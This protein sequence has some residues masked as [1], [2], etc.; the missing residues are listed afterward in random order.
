MHQDKTP[1]PPQIKALHVSP[2]CAPLSKKGG[3]GDVAG[4]LPKALRG[5][6]VDAR[7]LTP[8][9]PGVLDKARELGALPQRPVGAVSVAINWRA[10]TAKV[11]R[12]NISGL[13]VY[14]LENDELFSNGDIYPDTLNAETAEPMIFLSYAA[15]ELEH[16]AKWKPYIIH[17]HDWPT[18]A[19]PAALRWHRHYA[20]R[21]AD[22]DTV[23]TIHNIAH[24]GLFS[25]DCL[26]GWGFRPDSYWGTFE[27]YGQ[28]N[29]MKGAINNAEAV[30]AVS[31]SYSWDIQ[32]R[33]G[34]FGLDG[35]M[36]ANK[37]KLSGILNG[38]D[39]D[40]WNPRAD[41]LIPAHYSADRLDGKK[42]CRR[43]LMEKFGWE[44][45]GR[46]LVIFVGRLTE[47]KG[48]DIMLDAL[49]QF[50]PDGI[51]ALIIGSGSDMFNRRLED[52]RAAHAE[53]VRTVTG[54]SEET[55]HL[56]YA[57]G[58]ILVMPSL[59]E[60]CGLSQLIAFAYGTIPVARATGG[61]ADTVIDADGSPDGTGFLFTDYRIDELAKAL[62]RA[63]A[64]KADA[65]RW[66]RIMRSA[67]KRDFS[68]NASAAEY[69]GLYKKI[70]KSE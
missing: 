12:A 70:L 55:A 43:A 34:G 7:V 10:V 67:M 39:Y 30:T 60:P 46:P 1:Q 37:Q 25:Y 48:V 6:G 35:V 49:A 8:A 2:E 51:Y 21:A 52:F 3:L 57:G 65:E 36:A 62:G 64:A 19:I 24:Q 45:D 14:I 41:K 61:L 56:A 32:T 69:A 22:Y 33:D 40:V 20:S 18:A 59:F 13:P 42:S 5:A 29:L 54:F 58:D 4:S 27:F 15:M 53:C 38:I 44:D 50:M 68:W 28:V 11:W 16:A 23:H 9:W 47:Q 26:N 66:R 17:S 63:L 31:P